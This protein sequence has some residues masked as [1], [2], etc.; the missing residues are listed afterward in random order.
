MTAVEKIQIAI[1]RLSLSDRGR[2]AKWF[3]GWKDDDWD[4]E[5][6]R[7]FGPGGRYEDIPR[8]IEREIEHGPLLDLP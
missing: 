5:M 4:K 2:L 7:D 1:E 3:N 6:T 8:R